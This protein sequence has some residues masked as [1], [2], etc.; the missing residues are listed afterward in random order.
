MVK[1]TFLTSPPTIL[2]GSTQSQ[3]V[4]PSATTVDDFTN[5]SFNKQQREGLPVSGP[6]SVVFGGR[7]VRAENF[8]S[9][10]VQIY[11]GSHY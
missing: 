3:S 9:V 11:M 2:T 10:V 4:P 6:A 1:Y 8:C 7:V 5:I